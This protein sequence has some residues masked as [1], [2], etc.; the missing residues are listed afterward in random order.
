MM[1][2]SATVPLGEA[3]VYSHD[4]DHTGQSTPVIKNRTNSSLSLVPCVCHILGTFQASVEVAR[5][6]VVE[7]VELLADASTSPSPSTTRVAESS[8]GS[9]PEGRGVVDDAGTEGSSSSSSSSSN[10]SSGGGE[11]GGRGSNNGDVRTAEI[12]AEGSSLSPF[13]AA[14]LSADGACVAVKKAE[15]ALARAV[16]LQR[17]LPGQV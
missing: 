11:D 4:L 10:S 9:T 1:V 12:S 5:R 2:S 17:S 14:L 15:S 13:R 3:I 16:S 7:A 8:I 6:K